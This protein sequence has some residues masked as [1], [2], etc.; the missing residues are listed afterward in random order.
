[1]VASAP[2]SAVGGWLRR[3]SS[4]FRF[5]DAFLCSP[6]ALRYFGSGFSQRRMTETPAGLA[7]SGGVFNLK[8]APP[9]ACYF[10]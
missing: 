6:L 7:A 3:V 1:M 2:I 5:D 9:R 8:E 4:F 10:V